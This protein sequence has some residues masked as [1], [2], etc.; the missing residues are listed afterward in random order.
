MLYRVH[1][2]CAGF[3]RNNVSDSCEETLTNVCIYNLG[4]KVGTIFIP[5]GKVLPMDECGNQCACLD[6]DGEVS[7]NNNLS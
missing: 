4:C 6:K 7:Y 3:E 5:M 2:A 1:L